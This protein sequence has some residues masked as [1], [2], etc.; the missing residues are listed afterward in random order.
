M[1]RAAGFT[2]VIVLFA[3][4]AIGAIASRILEVS[5]TSEQ[6]RREA[7]LLHIGHAYREAIG[8]YYQSTPGTFKRYPD[9]L[10][11]LLQDPRTTTLRRPLRKL[12]RDP[13][14]SSLEWGLIRGADERI[15]GVYSLSLMKPIKTAGF[16]PSQS[17]FN[18]ATRYQDWQFVY[19]PPTV[20]T[21]K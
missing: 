18:G 14:T 15:M 8:V 5:M 9:N 2:Y 21:D 10:A 3:V 20:V 16:A 13:I 1:R 19:V 7:A 6:R 11:D 17:S 4:A 12:Y